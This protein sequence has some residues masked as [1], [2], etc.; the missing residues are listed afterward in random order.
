MQAIAYNVVS[1]D[2]WCIDMSPGNNVLPMFVWSYIF[3]F[4]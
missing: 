2:E 1:R 3:Y 4:Y